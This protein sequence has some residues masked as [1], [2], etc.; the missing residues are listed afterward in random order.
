MNDHESIEKD[1]VMKKIFDSQSL[2]LE[3]WSLAM[4]VF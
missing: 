1:D 3:K 2:M 4:I